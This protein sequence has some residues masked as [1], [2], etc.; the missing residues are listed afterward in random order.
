MINMNIFFEFMSMILK[1][2]MYKIN[3]SRFL[4][5]QSLLLFKISSCSKKR[6][7]GGGGGLNYIENF[8][9]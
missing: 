6:R 1:N 4:K 3:L 9:F 2:H 7:G 5:M 8:I